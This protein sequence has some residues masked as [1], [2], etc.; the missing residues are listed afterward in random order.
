MLDSC[1]QNVYRKNVGT[2][3]HNNNLGRR[4]P[5]VAIF[6]D[7]AKAFDIVSLDM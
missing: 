4:K 3:I 5:I 1:H 7:L 2:T 6:F